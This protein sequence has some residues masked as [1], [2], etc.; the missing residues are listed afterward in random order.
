MHVKSTKTH[1]YAHWWA[2][3]KMD[4]LFLTCEPCE[5]QKREIS[6][7]RPRQHLPRVV[8]HAVVVWSCFL[9][10]QWHG[11]TCAVIRHQGHK[12]KSTQQQ[13]VE[14]LFVF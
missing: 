5:F 10:A 12:R 13:C 3:D 4:A 1:N 6:R 2:Q 9:S 7:A 11:G 8:L 14:H